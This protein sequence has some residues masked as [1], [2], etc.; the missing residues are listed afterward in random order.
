[1]GL[2]WCSLPVILFYIW[3]CLEFICRIPVY[4]ISRLK[5]N[6]TD[7]LHDFILEHLPPVVI[8]ENVSSN[9]D[10]SNRPGEDKG[11]FIFLMDCIGFKG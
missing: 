4:S 1:M 7:D 10:V 2:H 9:A 5:T 8:N 3:G 6:L 11:I